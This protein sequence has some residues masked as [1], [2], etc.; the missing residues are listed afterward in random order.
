MSGE[1]VPIAED[2]IAFLGHGF[3]SASSNG[4]LAYTSG[5]AQGN[6]QLTWIDRYGKELG[7]V[8][9]PGLLYRPALLRRRQDRGSGQ[10]PASGSTWLSGSPPLGLLSDSLSTLRTTSFQSGLLMAATS[11]LPRAATRVQVSICIKNPLAA[12]R[13]RAPGPD[14]NSEGQDSIGL[15]SRRTLHLRDRNRSQDQS[16]RL[17]IA[18]LR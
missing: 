10:R 6:L 8:G 11:R 13:H 7:T 1:P 12:I 5:S 3:F 9:T 15:V 4:A 17:G 2:V 18:A 16:R 14:A